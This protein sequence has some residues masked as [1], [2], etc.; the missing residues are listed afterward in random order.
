MPRIHSAQERLESIARRYQEQ[1][2]DVL[3]WFTNREELVEAFNEALSIPKGQPIPVMMLYGVGGIGKTWFMN[4]A[5]EAICKPRQIPYAHLNFREEMHRS[6]ESALFFLRSEM[7]RR[8]R[9]KFSRFDLVWAEYAKKAL[10]YVIKKGGLIPE[11]L[12]TL[13]DLIDAL[14]LVPFVGEVAKAIKLVDLLGCRAA[15]WFQSQFGEHWG[16]IL[17]KMEPVDLVDVMPVAFAEDLNDNV[18]RRG[19]PFVLFLDTFEQIEGAEGAFVR[20]LAGTLEHILLTMAGRNR[21]QWDKVE[22][23]WADEA[24]LKQF[25]VGNFSESDTR[26]YLRQF[27]IVDEEVVNQLYQ[28]TQG[29]IQ[30]LALAVDLIRTVREKG[31]QATRERLRVRAK[32]ELLPQ[33]LS[34]L[35]GE[36]KDAVQIAAVPRWFS[37]EVLEQLLGQPESTDRLMNRLVRYSFVEP[38]REIEDAYRLHTVVRDLLLAGLQGKPL[39][40][41]WQERLVRHFGAKAQETQGDERL[42]YIIEQLYHEFN[43]DEAQGYQHFR[44]LFEQALRFRHLKECRALVQS[45]SDS[46]DDYRNHEIGLWVQKWRGDLL[47]IERRDREAAA[48][49][50]SLVSEAQDRQA[51]R[52]HILRGLGSTS[53][54]LRAYERGEELYQQGLE[55]ARAGRELVVEVDLLRRLGNIYRVRGEEEAARQYLL[56]ALKKAEAA[57]DRHAQALVLNS[58]GLAAAKFGYTREAQRYYAQAA[59]IWE[60]LGAN[61]RETG[62]LQNWGFVEIRLGNLD[63]ASNKFR[64]HLQTCWEE[65]LWNSV[66]VAL[67]NLGFVALECGHFE[68]AIFYRSQ[69]L[70]IRHARAGKEAF[71]MQALAECLTRSGD[72][73]QAERLLLGAVEIYEDVSPKTPHLSRV[74][75]NLAR[76]NTLEGRVDKALG[77]AE[78]ALE[79]AKARGSADY[80]IRA[81]TEIGSVME[82]KG[83]YNRALQYFEDALEAARDLLARL[84]EKDLLIRQ[85]RTYLEMEEWQKARRCLEQGLGLATDIGTRYA[86]VDALV[87]LAQ[88]NHRTGHSQAACNYLSQAETQAEAEPVMEVVVVWDQGPLS[89]M[90]ERPVKA[91]PYHDWLSE[92]HRLQAKWSLD[93]GCTSEAARQYVE[94]LLCGYR[95][96]G[97]VGA[98]VM[99]DMCMQSASL[100]GERPDLAKHFLSESLA[101]CTGSESEISP[102]IG[103]AVRRCLDQI[104]ASPD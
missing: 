10:G 11:E 39:Y 84:L 54:R 36:E 78:S 35:S 93:E 92:I 4:Y 7:L 75:R 71:P 8:Y 76:L 68:G 73:D 61:I 48:V 38:K 91:R 70:S 63:S 17:E 33:L 14:E 21:L 89:E 58:F 50:E 100:A 81:V 41:E 49:Y 29:H 77:F 90:E 5:M 66:E 13:A 16:R 27:D 104:G 18:H 98:R 96:N 62:P 23:V 37:G 44:Q 19:T 69:R 1:H 82:A 102:S 26:Q 20:E 103:D 95:Y 65:G 60:E 43:L 101:L 74:F 55:T 9:Y 32:E 53:R 97:T 40:R 88:L 15:D 30:Y 46:P 47:R 45:L 6:P 34:E 52:A 57:G 2:A 94:A 59:S 28:I 99:E 72:W 85:G 12:K 3:R 42:I 67:S 79:I 24:C 64:E 51:L 31:K 80:Q 83:E 86:A 87:G 56:E 22:E 25:L